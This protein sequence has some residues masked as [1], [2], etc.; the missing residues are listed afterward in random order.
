M[1][2]C[3]LKEY[4]KGQQ[5]ML[6]FDGSDEPYNYM[7]FI[8]YLESIGTYG[9][10]NKPTKTFEES[11][12][13]PKLLEDC[14]ITLLFDVDGCFDEHRTSSFV[15]ELVNE[16][17]YDIFTD[18]IVEIISSSY[19]NPDDAIDDSELFDFF[20]MDVNEFYSLFKNTSV[21]R[22]KLMKN[23]RDEL[24][25]LYNKTFTTNE[26]GQIYIERVLDI[27]NPIGRWYDKDWENTGEQRDYFKTITKQYQGIGECWTYIDGA[28][29]CYNTILTNGTKINLKGWVNPDDVNWDST[30]RLELMDEYEIRLY[31][32]IAIQ[33]DEVEVIEGDNRGKRLPLKGSIVVKT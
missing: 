11:I 9:K 32:N 10:I 12:S 17:G 22:E 13:N 5:L 7:Q 25:W 1:V 28:G 14:G 30:V 29:D 19:S 27:P 18:D 20:H 23:G 21:L 16:N 24:E 3:V 33:I 6:P 4:H 31:K 15:R 2:K 8:E 26:S